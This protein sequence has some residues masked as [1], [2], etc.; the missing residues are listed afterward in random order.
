[1]E[2]CTYLLVLTLALGAV[3]CDTVPTEVPFEAEPSFAVSGGVVASVS[4]SGHIPQGESDRRTFTFAAQRRADGTV[5][6]QFTLMI[7]QPILGSENPS[8]TRIEM[9]VTCVAISGNRAWVGGVVR[10]AS[11][12]DW[13]GGETGWAVQDNG[14]GA[15][16]SDLIS[17][18]DVPREPGFAKTV[19]DSRSRIPN[20]LIESGN[21]SVSDGGPANDVFFPFSTLVFACGDWI[22]VAGTFHPVSRISVDGSGGFHTKSHINATGV[23]VGLL[24][25]NVYNWNDAINFQESF[26][27]PHATFTSQQSFL[28]IGRASAPNQRLRMIMHVTVTPDGIANVTADRF[29]LE[30]S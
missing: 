24:T 18:M 3:G 26:Q 21:V 29:R 4:G 14:E 8:V 28:L 13:V 19:C 12:P 11:N 9:E 27:P 25:E 20:I 1:M 10:N 6:G 30:C 23:G 2:R 5:S 15:G 7:S 16:S 22:Q 17:L